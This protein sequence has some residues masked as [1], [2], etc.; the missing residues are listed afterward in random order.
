MYVTCVQRSSDERIDFIPHITQSVCALVYVNLEYMDLL[1]A[2]FRDGK[3]SR[4]I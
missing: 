1:Y 2:K 4:L 3:Q